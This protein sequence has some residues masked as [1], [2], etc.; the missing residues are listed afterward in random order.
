[1]TSETDY[2]LD[3][4]MFVVD[5]QAMALNASGYYYNYT[6]GDDDDTVATTKDSE[7]GL[8]QYESRS[9]PEIV[10]VVIVVVALSLI[11]PRPR[12]YFSFR[13]QVKLK[14]GLTSRR[15]QNHGVDSR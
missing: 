7:H 11:T 12:P 5:G 14:H 13:G 4:D 2:Q 3:R 9:V 15:H 6:P 10:V 1:M 8:S